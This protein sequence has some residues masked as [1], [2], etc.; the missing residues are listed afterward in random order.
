VYSVFEM[1]I[2]DLHGYDGTVT[3]KQIWGTSENLLSVIRM[4]PSGYAL[5][6]SCSHHQ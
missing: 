2:Q 5:Y 1:G 3:G 4:H 6:A